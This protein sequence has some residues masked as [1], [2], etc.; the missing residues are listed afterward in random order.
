[1]GALGDGEE[2]GRSGLCSLGRL[3]STIS[4]AR[5]LRGEWGWPNGPPG[6]EKGLPRRGTLV[7]L[8]CPQILK[9]KEKTGWAFNE[10]KLRWETGLEAPPIWRLD[11]GEFA[12]W[13]K[14]R[15][16]I[17]A[18]QVSR[19]QSASALGI[20]ADVFHISPDL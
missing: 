2:L 12:V 5:G 8:Q 14:R 11:S 19:F 3:P 16:K 18:L 7:C 17:W 4:L 15:V 9:R 10:A 20:W 1:M 6:R 13:P